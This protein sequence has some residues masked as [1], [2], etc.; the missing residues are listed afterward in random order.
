MNVANYNGQTPLFVAVRE[1]NLKNI[2][3]LVEEAGAK[4]DLSGV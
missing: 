3:V 2:I 4:I 1:G